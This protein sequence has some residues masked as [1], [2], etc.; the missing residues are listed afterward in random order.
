MTP[1]LLG[2][3]TPPGK[4]NQ[5]VTITISQ[6]FESFLD[7]LPFF[8]DAC[9]VHLC[10]SLSRKKQQQQKKRKAPAKKKAVLTK[11]PKF[12]VEDMDIDDDLDE[13]DEGEAE[14]EVEV[15]VEAE[16]RESVVTID[17]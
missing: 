10:D 7:L 16:D 2:V 8:D 4:E 15:E 1:L 9:R 12:S 17:E 11:R 14:V 5:T 6:L 3:K 13:E